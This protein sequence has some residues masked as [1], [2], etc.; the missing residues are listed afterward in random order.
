MSPARSWKA[1]NPEIAGVGFSPLV[2]NLKSETCGEGIEYTIKR[3]TRLPTKNQAADLKPLVLP[4]NV[5]HRSI[6]CISCESI[7][8]HSVLAW[9]QVRTTAYL[10]D[11]ATLAFHKRN[12]HGA[13]EVL[14][15][16]IP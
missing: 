11:S 2:R 15:R 16:V 3:G 1:A 13:Q 8:I 12:G 5:K 6:L 10:P 7:V 14:D 4:V 9:S